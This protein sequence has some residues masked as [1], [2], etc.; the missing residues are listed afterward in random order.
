[1]K[2][3]ARKAVL[4]RALGLE[5]LEALA[6]DAKERASRAAFH[7]E[8]LSAKLPALAGYSVT[9][10]DAAVEAAEI[11]LSEAQSRANDIARNLEVARIEAA[12]HTLLL[13]RWE[14]NQQAREKLTADIKAAEEK[15]AD[16]RRKVANN[17]A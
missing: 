17:E 10:A 8:M 12:D 3:T 2:P 6:A 9:E 1:L 7:V 4:L 15:L 5:K 11:A 14:E 16:V 13:R